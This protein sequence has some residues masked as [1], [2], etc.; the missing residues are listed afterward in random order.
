MAIFPSQKTNAGSTTANSWLTVSGSLGETQR[1]PIPRGALE[2]VFHVCIIYLYQ[3]K[4]KA[5]KLL[6]LLANLIFK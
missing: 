2:F 4:Y 1:V 5:T 3:I 6:C